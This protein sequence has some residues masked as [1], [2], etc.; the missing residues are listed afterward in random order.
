MYYLLFV[1]TPIARRRRKTAP[2]VGDGEAIDRSS[3]PAAAVVGSAAASSPAVISDGAAAGAVV[4]PPDVEPDEIGV[5]R[6]RRASV[7]AVRA[8]SSRGPIPE[9]VAALFTAPPADNAVR[10]RIGYRVVRVSSTPDELLGEEIAQL[11]RG[12]EVEIMRAQG[13]YRL[14][15][16]PNGA[17]GWIHKMTLANEEA[18]DLEPEEPSTPQAD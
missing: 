2:A 8:S 11:D 4:P 17:Q 9:H 3:A 5:P 7:R 12:D 16:L 10:R 15:R 14:V 6:W 18:P 1:V 13:A